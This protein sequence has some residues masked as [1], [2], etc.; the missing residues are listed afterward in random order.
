MMV[1][2]GCGYLLVVF[3]VD[4]DADGGGEGGLIKKQVR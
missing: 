3:V 2:I 4:D 1:A